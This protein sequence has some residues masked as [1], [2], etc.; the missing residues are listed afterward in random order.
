MLFDNTP[1]SVQIR[2]HWSLVPYSRFYYPYAC[3]GIFHL[4]A[5]PSA[6]KVHNDIRDRAPRAYLNFVVND[7]IT[8]TIKH[9][10]VYDS[11][12]T[13]R[14]TFTYTRVDAEGVPLRL[15]PLI[16]QQPFWSLSVLSPC[17][18][19]IWSEIRF[20]P[21][22]IR[23]VS[24]RFVANRTP[25]SLLFFFRLTLLVARETYGNNSTKKK[26]RIATIQRSSP[27]YY[28]INLRRWAATNTCVSEILPNFT[29][30]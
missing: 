24:F 1:L 5:R 3:F 23:T 20:D 30:T 17:K 19:V 28:C 27:H 13:V 18:S 4:I 14:V 2:K 29:E 9:W 15:S 7:G 12:W 11:S 21:F 8:D 16:G 10:Q 25:S 26:G 22:S 6:D